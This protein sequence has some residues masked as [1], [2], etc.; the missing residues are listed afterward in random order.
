M[1]RRKIFILVALCAFLV[2]DRARASAFVQNH[3]IFPLGDREALM[4]N[5]GV[6]AGE[7]AGSVYY[8]PAGL[9]LLTTSSVKVQGTIYSYSRDEA[10][11]FARYDGTGLPFGVSRFE[12]IPHTAVSVVRLGGW[13]AAGGV[14][15]PKANRLAKQESWTT[16]NREVVFGAISDETELWFGGA[17]SRQLDDVWLVGGAVFASRWQS[18]AMSY[19]DVSDKTGATYLNVTSAYLDASVMSLVTVVGVLARVSPEWRFGARIQMPYA[20]LSGTAD[21]R[22][23]VHL[24]DPAVSP[25][26]TRTSFNETGVARHEP[27]ADFTLG[28]QYRPDPSLEVNVDI[29]VA[30]ARQYAQ[31]SFSG[32]DSGRVALRA[33]PRVSAGAEWR[34]APKLAL[35]GGVS[36]SPSPLTASSSEVNGGIVR[37]T[38]VAATAGVAMGGERTTSAVGLFYLVGRG[39]IIPI[40]APD[41]TSAYRSTSL[42]LVVSFGYLL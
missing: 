33:T 10:D 12:A 7:S 28:A 38:A 13:V 5:T 4:A 30:L 25:T 16:P 17:I 29:G 31:F 22:G 24:F 26:P 8:N 15:I 9:A 36:Y 27:P 6:G 3:N 35:R 37:N 42:G 14:L 41:K 21:A 39:D 18:L 23:V 19:Q 40:E 1:P 11:E 32:V 20:R 34:L 2:L